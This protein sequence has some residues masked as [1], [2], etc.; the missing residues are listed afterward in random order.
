[1]KILLSTILSLV[2]SLS[3]WAQQTFQWGIK[4]G[5]ESTDVIN[6]ITSLDDDIYITGS[7]SGTFYS[8]GEKVEG[9]SMSDIY[10]LKLDQKGNTAWLHSL[11]GDGEGNGARVTAGEDNIYLGG[12]LSGTVKQGKHE[13][14]GEGKAL[15]IASWNKQGKI[16]WLTRLPFIGNATLDVLE[17]A[18]DGSLFGGGMISGTINIGNDTL[19]SRPGKRA[20][21]F[22]LSPEGK[23][24]SLALS[25]GKGDHRL[26]AAKFGKDGIRYLL[27]NT[28]GWMTYGKNATLFDQK[29]DFRGLVLVKETKG[30]TNWL[31]Y[32]KG[33]GYIDGVQ[34]VVSEEDNV[35]VCINYSKN[36]ALPD[37]LLST[38]ALEDVVIVNYS[39]E[40]KQNW[41]RQIKSPV[42][43]YAMDA[44]QT[45][46]GKLLITG[47]FRDT[48]TFGDENILA[49][50]DKVEES[51]FLVQLNE[52]GELTWHDQPGEQASA[53]GK[54]VTIGSQGDIYMAGGFKDE[55]SFNGEKLKSQGK[56]DVL[57]AKY[58]NCDQL[59]VLIDNS[60]PL[61]L[62]G[63]VELTV[64]DKSFETCIWNDSVWG[65]NFMVSGPGTYT[66]EAFDQK[67]CSA[68][69]TIVI[70]WAEIPELGL[71]EN[72]TLSSGD[73][74][75]L[76]ANAGF[77]D[78]LWN[79]GTV[80]ANLVIKYSREA[81][82][83][84][85][86]VTAETF[87]GCPVSDTTIVQFSE[88]NTQ[89]NLYSVSSLKVY[90]NPV[91]NNLSWYYKT[92]KPLDITVKLF[93]G[94]GVQVY[95]EEFG[96]YIPNSVQNIDMREM[97]SGN[98]ML[99]LVI[100]E[101]SFSEKI[102]KK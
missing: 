84:A 78:Y 98:Y 59:E 20:Y 63:W 64:S 51:M 44:R 40:G 101:N 8:A 55:V 4:A 93:D 92:D 24:N 57:V 13:Y 3:G 19:S 82:S 31:K 17:V 36:I 11:T 54:S 27:F 34:L 74:V 89:Y 30:E 49:D 96:N 79:D 7:F 28:F 73:N 56:E 53:F 65:K 16:D 47:Y 18:A 100:G 67:E 2:L 35:S 99:T 45:R 42:V 69:D 52:Q 70:D 38:S 62:D 26:V 25:K 32:I 6:D 90:P 81:D 83:M 80:G 39:Q 15:F 86:I 58:F 43:C 102:V 41:L 88:D 75:V 22:S 61:C 72:I 95:M 1:M 97:V 5:G 77:A 87:E 21:T 10:L 85:C 33:D 46:N 23:L 14:N 76:T 50:N 48:Y 9:K 66:I 68:R 94:K 91:T 29:E 37:T 12:T 60:G 71:P